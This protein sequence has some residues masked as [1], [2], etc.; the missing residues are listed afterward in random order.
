MDRI[1]TVDGIE[2]LDGRGDPTVQATVITA[3]GIVATAIAPSGRSAGSHEAQEVR[4]GD[5]S[6]FGGRGVRAHLATV[7]PTINRELSGHPLDVVA[8]DALLCGLDGTANKSKLGTN[9]TSCISLAVAKAAAASHGIP[10]YRF[11]NPLSVRLPVPLMNLING[12]RHAYNHTPVQEF[13]ILPVGAG[14]FASALSWTMEVYRKLAQIVEA[15]DGRHA[16]NTGDEGG[17][18]PDVAGVAEGIELLERAVRAAGLEAGT[19]YGLDMATTHL[20]DGATGL[21]RLEQGYRRDELLGLYESLIDRFPIISIE[22]PVMEDD[23]EGLALLTG[24]VRCQFVGDD[25]FVTNPDRLKTAIAQKAGNALLWKFNQI[26]TITEAWR[27]AE[28]ARQAGY[29]IV[30]SERSGD[31][32]DPAIADLAVALGASQIKTGAPVRG[33]RTAKYNRL[34]TIAHELGS[35]ATYAG[36]MLLE[37]YG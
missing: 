30:V 23:L 14:D 35:Q 31:T 2:V 17:L 13:I 12:G 21:Y 24:R 18:T 4:D 28:L 22:D 26:G 19:R 8:V 32:E 1:V 20:Y 33:E 27:A 29:E 7:I 9:V 36:G 10:L 11:L 37:R 16:L 25:L 15:R 34:L 6:R 5:A 3:S